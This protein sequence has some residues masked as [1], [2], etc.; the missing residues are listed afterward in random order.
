MVSNSILN[1]IKRLMCTDIWQ[2][3]T[4]SF[5]TWGP[6][7]CTFP[8]LREVD[9]APKWTGYPLL[10]VSCR[11]DRSVEVHSGEMETDSQGRGFQH[12][13]QFQGS[14]FEVPLDASEKSSLALVFMQSMLPSIAHVH[15]LMGDIVPHRLSF[16]RTFSQLLSFNSPFNDVNSLLCRS[17]GGFLFCSSTACI[18]NSPFLSSHA[19]IMISCL[20]SLH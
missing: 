15:L 3:Q 17:T 7:K 6:W 1:N 9:C 20:V 19:V 5:D 8:F 11:R 18:V 13:S 2:Y 10:S 14:I 12:L 4:F 16:N